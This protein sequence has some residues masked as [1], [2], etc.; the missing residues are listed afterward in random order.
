MLLDPVA[1]DAP[2]GPQPNFDASAVVP[3]VAPIPVSGGL[4]VARAPGSARP[5]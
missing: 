5:P 3:E 1:A 2:A 4:A